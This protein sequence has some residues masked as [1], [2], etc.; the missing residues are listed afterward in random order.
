MPTLS[1]VTVNGRVIP[2]AAIAAE[3]QNHPAAKGKP[4]A[5]WKAAARALVL[6]ELLL[7][8]AAARGLTAAPQEVAPGLTETADE[9]LIRALLELAVI[10]DP[11]EEARLRAVFDAEPDRFRAPP[12]WEAAHILIPAVPTDAA[13]RKGARAIARGLIDELRA[14]PGRFAALAAEHS[15][16]DS[17]AAGGYLGQI[18]PGDTVPEFEAVLR[19]LPQGMIA[20]EPV[21]TRYGFHVVRL[22]ARAEGAALPYEAVAPRL[23]LAA[24]KAAWA[25]AA[26]AYAAALLARAEVAGVTLPA[27]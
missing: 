25:R 3:A 18:A 20:P 22:D 24:E 11:V 10:P 6:R 27:A 4:G 17:R 7:Q 26:R 16:C 5:P 13:A 8:E 15:A 2:A 19:K 1:S 12:L 14:Q 9:A 21:E 23:R